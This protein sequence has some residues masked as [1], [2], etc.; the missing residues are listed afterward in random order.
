MEHVYALWRWQQAHGGTDND[1]Y[2]RSN[3]IYIYYGSMDTRTMFGTMNAL[4][5]YYD[6]ARYPSTAGAGGSAA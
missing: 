6:E 1:R 4:D 3:H 2:F 5:F